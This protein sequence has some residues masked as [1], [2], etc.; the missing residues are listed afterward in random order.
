MGLDAAPGWQRRETFETTLSALGAGFVGLGVGLLLG[1]QVP[2][3]GWTLL[4]GG[5]ATHSVGMVYLH[6]RRQGHGADQPKWLE[7]LY[8]TCWAVLLVVIALVS[9]LAFR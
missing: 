9:W 3:L 4:L 8:W 2:A 5:V 7:W 6:R 1:L